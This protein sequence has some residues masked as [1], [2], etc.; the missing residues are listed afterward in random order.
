MS[1]L[2]IING[3]NVVARSVIRRLAPLY[4]SIKVCDYKPYRP[5]VICWDELALGLQAVQGGGREKGCVGKSHDYKHSHA[6]TRHRGK[7]EGSIFHPRLL[8]SGAR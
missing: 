6:G 8:H 1:S 2:T 3:A 7:P 5:S 4:Q